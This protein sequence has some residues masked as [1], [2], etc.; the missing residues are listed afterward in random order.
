MAKRKNHSGHNVTAKAHRNGIHRPKQHKYTSLKG[1]SAEFR[2]VAVL[3]LFVYCDWCCA[4]AKNN[5]QIRVFIGFLAVFQMDPKYVRNLKYAK[6]GNRRGGAKKK[7][8]SEKP[9]KK[10]SAKA[11]TKST[12]K[13]EKP[14]VAA[15]AAAPKAASKKEEKPKGKDDKPKAAAAKKEDKPKPAPK[16]AA[17]KE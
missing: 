8:K 4:R 6:A 17:K 5:A 12:K 13:D 16:A 9:D 3:F 15:K 11:S 2:C 7:E 10:A 14:K 1:V